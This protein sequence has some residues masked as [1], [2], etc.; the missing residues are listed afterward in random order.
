[1]LRAAVALALV[2]D[3]HH[4]PDVAT[5]A[6]REEVEEVDVLYRRYGDIASEGEGQPI[7][8]DADGSDRSRPFARG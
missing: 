4:A 7:S 6:S 1:M 3:A 5:S 2:E 8:A